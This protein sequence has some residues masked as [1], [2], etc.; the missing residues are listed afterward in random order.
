[1]TP[2]TVAL[3][4]AD[5]IAAL[6]IA[7]AMLIGGW[8]RMTPGV[9]GAFHDDGVYA[10]T[11]KALANGDGYRLIQLP[12]APPQTKYPILYPAFL[13]LFWHEAETLPSRI[14]TMQIATLLVAALAVVG[15]YLYAVRYGYA[16]RAAAFAGCGDRGARRRTFSTIRR[17]CS[18][19]CRSLSP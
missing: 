11:A 14:A 19:S 15:F 4:R 5:A 3:R 6:A 10:L 16:G 1:M 8:M 13:S 7:A 9:A 2:V 18:R 12:G 17:A